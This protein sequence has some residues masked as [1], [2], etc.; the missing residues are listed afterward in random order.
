MSI[1]LFKATAKKNWLLALIFF[2]VLT[3]YSGVMISMYNPADMEKLMSMFELFPPEIMKALGFAEAFTDITGY[4]A[5]WL[6]GL[7]MIGFPMVYSILL[8]NR[9][10]AKSVDSG[11]MA[12]LLATPNSRVKIILTKYIYAVLSIVAILGLLF[13]VNV[14]LSQAMFPGDMDVSAFARLNLTVI[15]VNIVVLS[16]AF[17]CSCVF[18]DAKYAMG[19]GAGIPIAFLLFNMLGGASDKAEVLKNI[20]IFGWY[21]PMKLVNGQ[22][23]AGVNAAYIGIVAV[24]FVGSIWIFKRKRLPI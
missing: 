4:L 19:F 21:D 12:C 11:S 13:A 14:G 20:S 1:A 5:S 9:L 7:L 17:F 10:V 8:G 15:L 3:M 16:I 24:L 18:T 22:S 23:Y 2:G 6:Y